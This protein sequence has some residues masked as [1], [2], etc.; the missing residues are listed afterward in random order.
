MTEQRFDI[1]V[2]DKVAKT[3]KTELLAIGAAAGTTR[4]FIASLKAEMGTLASAAGGMNSTASA[5]SRAM[6]EE[7]AASNVASQ[8]LVKQRQEADA[9][10]R[11]L[12]EQAKAERD[13]ASARSAGARQ[14]AGGGV[15]FGPPA[16]G[17]APTPRSGGTS[18]GTA[19]SAAQ[20]ARSIKQV[21]DA[22]G[23]AAHQAA[24]L[25]FQLNDVFVSLASGQKPMTVFIQQG[26]QIAQIPAQGGM[27]WREFA[28]AATVSLG[29]IERTGNAALDAAAKQAAQAAAAV[30]Q[31]NASVVSNVRVAETEVALATAQQQVAVTAAEQAAAAARLTA[32]NEA[33]AAS[34]SEA[35]VTAKALATAQGNAAEAQTASAAAS[36]R[37]LSTLGIVGIATAA[38]LGVAAAGIALLTREAN[39]DD[40]LKTYTKEM[41]YTSAEVKKLNAVTVT[42]GDTAKA[43]FQVGFRRI[44]AE[45]GFNASD[46]KKTWNSMLDDILA[47]TRKNVSE[48]Y[49]LIV[50]IKRTGD[51]D[52]RTLGDPKKLWSDI[53]KDYAEAT[54]DAD[55]AFGDVIKQSRKNSQ[56]RQST[57]A[58]AM[59]DKPRDKKDRTAK[60]WDRSQELKN[61][62]AELDAQINLLG[63]Y[64]DELERANQLE[65]I[66]KKFR[67]HNVPLTKD[68][69]AALSAKIQKLQEG[70]RVQEAMTAADEA[71]NG[72]SRKYEDTISALNNMLESGKLSLQQYNE[73]MNLATRAFEDATDPLA[74]L[75]RELQRNGELMG[76]YGRDKDV[77]SYIQQLQQAAEAQ[78]KSIFERPPAAVNDNGEIIANGPT[79][80]LTPEAQ[81]M[82]DQYRQQQKQT[83]YGQYFEQNDSRTGMQDPNDD[84][85][86]LNHHKE[87][88]EELKRLRDEDVISEGEAAQRKKDLDKDYLDARLSYT[89]NILGNLTVL[90]QSKNR[91]LA[92]IGKAAAIAEATIDGVRAVQKALAAPPGPPYTIPTAIAVGV[93]SAANVAKIAGIGFEKGGYTGNGGTKDIAGAVH[94]QEYVFDAAA[95][96]RIGVP[97]L[98]AMR[99][100]TQLSQPA[101]SNGG[102]GTNVTIRPMP[103]VYMEEVRTPTGEIEM[104]ARRITREEAPKA[105]AADLRRGGN[106]HTGQAMKGSYGLQRND[107]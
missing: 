86:V 76:L 104:I 54:A 40:G 73:Q 20:A 92:A 107:R 36:A 28:K 25:G 3:I 9:L 90:S 102:G 7:A 14:P 42:F 98:D 50:A 80:R 100:G 41:G 34:N 60:G 72:A 103:G 99:R 70:R 46:I 8:A 94:G 39:K 91:E 58:T 35:A 59:Y 61:T 63:L 106:S 77:A 56:D 18:G 21:G 84:S 53:K 66:A 15:P 22:S 95:T 55:R 57:M 31:A 37:S 5:S 4:G 96:K 88:Y 93:M 6:R 51:R 10:T 75:N 101:N 81:G 89:Q 33:L 82:V 79:K 68:E 27:S 62:N 85:Y 1:I 87:L 74:A 19:S 23:L 11:S 64:G 24:N 105:V 47:D 97:A 44:A 16:P 13:L 2:Q 12:R 43:V 26:A 67:D 52:V 71:A 83:E 49:G 38:A 45:F 30:A 17:P 48:I 78:G 29:V 65:Q 32:A 69:T